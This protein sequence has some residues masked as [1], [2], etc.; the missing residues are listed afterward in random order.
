MVQQFQ[1]RYTEGESPPNQN[2]FVKNCV[3]TLTRLNFSH[4]QSSLHLMQ[5][6]YQDVISTAQNSSWT[7]W[8]GCLLVLLPSFVSPLP[9][10]QNISLCRPFSSKETK[11]SHW[12]WDPIN[13][14]G[15]AWWSCLSW[16]KTAQHSARCWQARCHGGRTSHL[17]ATTEDVSSANHEA[18]FSKLPDKKSGWPFD[19]EEQIP[20]QNPSHQ[21]NRWSF[22]SL[23]TS[24]AMLFL[25]HG[26]VAVFHWI[27][28]SFISGS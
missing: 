4:L 13:K 14:E 7:H 16:S 12:G 2:L 21:R 26:E 25:G 22:F 10:Q 6:T 27:D 15:G 23:L 24:L 8:L 18:T 28:C 1:Y 19:P 5:Y 9:H 11:K 17:S 3:F 20:S